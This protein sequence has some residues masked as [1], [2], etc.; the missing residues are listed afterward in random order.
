MRLFLTITITALALGG[1]AGDN[2]DTLADANVC[3]PATQESQAVTDHLLPSSGL[4]IPAR[5]LFWGDRFDR[6]DN[7]VGGCTNPNGAKINVPEVPNLQKVRLDH[8]SSA[9]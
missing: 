7:A 8:L 5:A 4:N 1:C 3:A 6:D 2:Y 9:I